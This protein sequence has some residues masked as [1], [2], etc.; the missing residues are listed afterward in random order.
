[1]SWDR[2]RRLFHAASALDGAERDTFL[3][4]ACGDDEALAAEVRS[5]LAWHDEATGFLEAPVARVAD[6]A[7]LA[8]VDLPAAPPPAPGPED[9]IGTSL[10]PWRIVALI[11][12]GGM[13]EVYRAERADA[14]FSREV[15][16]KVMG[17]GDLA[18]VAERFRRERETLAALDH[19]NIARVFD[20]GAT[21]AGRPYFVM[22]LVDGVPVDAYCDER[23]L[24]VEG[25]LRLFLAVCA[26]VQY[27]HQ[28]L[29]VHRDIKPDNILVGRDGTPKLLDF[30]V[31]KLLGKGETQ[32]A[33]ED[34]FARTWLMTPDFA[35]PEQVFGQAV[36][37]ATDV[38]S[39]GVLLHVLLTGLRPYR[40]SGDTRVSLQRQLATA[41]PGRP[42]ALAGAGDEGARERAARRGTTPRQLARRLGGDLDAI[43]QR[44]LQRDPAAR[45]ATVEQLIDDLQRH[46]AWQPVSA[47][48]REVRYVAGRFLRRHAVGVALAATAVLLLAAGVAAIAWQARL[49][50]EARARA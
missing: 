34:G 33:E 17:G 45:Y 35:S 24:G 7:G 13:G 8:G 23:R 10:G 38:Y 39:L 37:T 32:A 42:S 16:V 40:L 25:R 47:R 1:M 2:A 44:A 3:R 12:R 36:T 29:V 21:P 18:Q 46:L 28:N 31:A 49:A 14:A 50:A 4:E 26:G 30:G 22:E 19:P 48:R 43:L 41:D 11:G 9:L 15:A 27:A 6:L 5:L 20:G